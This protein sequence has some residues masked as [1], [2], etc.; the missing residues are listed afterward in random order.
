M[1]THNAKSKGERVD[2][3]AFQALVPGGQA[4]SYAQPCA[5]PGAPTGG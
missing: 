3:D 5:A 1:G 4:A 2:I